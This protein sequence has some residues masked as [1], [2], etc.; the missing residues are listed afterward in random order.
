MDGDR[1]ILPNNDD[2]SPSRRRCLVR[3][4]QRTVILNVVTEIQLSSG[5]QGG[6]LWMSEEAYVVPDMATT[7]GLPS[8]VG[9][10]RWSPSF[11]EGDE[12]VRVFV[13]D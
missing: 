5:V 11:I 7:P 8:P 2:V 12:H 1:P 3:E 6:S 4:R 10:R 9:Q 13:G